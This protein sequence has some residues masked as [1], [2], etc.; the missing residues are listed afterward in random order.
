MVPVLIIFPVLQLPGF[1]LSAQN[2]EP[3]INH[4]NLEEIPGNRIS[5]ISQD[6]GNA[7]IFSGNT[8]VIS[9]DF[10]EWQIHSVPNIP[11]A[12]STDS[13]LPLIYVGG[14]G[15]YGYLLKTAMGTYE[16][17]NL[18]EEET[19][20]DINRIYQDIYERG[21]DPTNAQDQDTEG[22]LSEKILFPGA[23]IYYQDKEIPLN[24]LNTL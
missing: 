23:F 4:I 12:V 13:V 14:R 10:E 17:H 19:R 1:N 11:R 20:G 18:T 3:Y 24:F 9:F 6:L 21:L 15:F 16:Y 5:S 7:M 2:G 8:G 22:G